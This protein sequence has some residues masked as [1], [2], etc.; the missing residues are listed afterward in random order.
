MAPASF[1][2]AADWNDDDDDDDDDDLDPLAPPFLLRLV[3]EKAA[4]PDAAAAEAEADSWC[5]FGGGGGGVGSCR[6]LRGTFQEVAPLA[7]CQ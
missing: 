3:G 5:G 7:A 2:C 6:L 1:A 4:E